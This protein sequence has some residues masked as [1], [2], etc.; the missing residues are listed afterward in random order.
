MKRP[1]WIV[2]VLVT[3]IVARLAW[4]SVGNSHRASFESAPLNPAT[5]AQDSSLVVY[6]V[7]VKSNAP[8]MSF[9]VQDVWKDMRKSHSNI[10]GMQFS[11]GKLPPKVRSPEGAVIF[12]KKK[13]FDNGHLTPDVFA[14]ATDGR[15]ENMTVVQYKQVCGF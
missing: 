9:V 8:Q 3:M 11:C 5:L 14:V 15:I 12:F 2:A 13:I 10:S 1:S 7:F 4:V 6:A